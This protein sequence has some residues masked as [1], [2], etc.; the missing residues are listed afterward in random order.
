M[1]SR[2]ANLILEPR[3]LP[4]LL[5]VFVLGVVGLQAVFIAHT[6][7]LITGRPLLLGQDHR[8]LSHL[9][10]FYFRRIRETL[11]SAF[12]RPSSNPVPEASSDA[13]WDR[14]LIIPFITLTDEGNRYIVFVEAPGLSPSNINLRLRGRELSISSVVFTAAAPPGSLQTRPAFLEHRV[15]LPGPVAETGPP[16]AETI[17]TGRL[18]VTMHKAEQP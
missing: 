2:F 8:S 4:V 14:V 7:K 17:S 12:Y 15:R 13:D 5:I 1:R 9:P 18:R 6:H 3:R 16:A 10:P 11:E